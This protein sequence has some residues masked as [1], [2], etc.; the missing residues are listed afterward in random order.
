MSEY[1]TYTVEANS[2][3]INRKEC[4]HLT[5][6][7]A[8]F[9]YDSCKEFDSLL[10]IDDSVLKTNINPFVVEPLFFRLRL[11]RIAFFD[12]FELRFKKIAKLFVALFI[13]LA[14]TFWLLA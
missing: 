7:D 11:F 6:D 14:S 4:E 8:K 10:P 13:H 3:N 5:F 1:K 12:L 2:F 9:I